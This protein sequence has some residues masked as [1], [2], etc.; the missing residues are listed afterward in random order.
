MRTRQ[1]FG[2]I[3]SR[4]NCENSPLGIFL[5]EKM[6]FENRGSRL[7]AAREKKRK[8]MLMRFCTCCIL[9]DIELPLAE[10]FVGIY[11]LGE[12]FF[13]QLSFCPLHVLLPPL[14]RQIL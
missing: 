11:L 14:C 13:S 5:V 4:A 1:L 9:V 8:E 2:M 6:S 10:S 12:F 7:Q 3:D